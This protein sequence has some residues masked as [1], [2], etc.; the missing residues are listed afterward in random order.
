MKQDSRNNPAAEGSRL[1][2]EGKMARNK[3]SFLFPFLSLLLFLVLSFLRCADSD[4]ARDPMMPV[5]EQS[6]E[7]L[8]EAPGTPIGLQEAN[9]LKTTPEEFLS[10]SDVRI[11]PSRL[12][13]MYSQGLWFKIPNSKV[14]LFDFGPEGQKFKRPCRIEIDLSKADLSQAEKRKIKVYYL[15][16]KKLE[17]VPSMLNKKTGK[18]V[19][20]VKHFSRYALSRE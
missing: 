20:W 18:M 11:V 4:V 16:N 1:T 6:E 13:R 12:D 19:F 8:S 9:L 17:N 15:G 14:Y 5:I 3:V 7:I 2:K 10:D